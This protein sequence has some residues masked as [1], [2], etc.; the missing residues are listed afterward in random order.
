MVSVAG[1]GG[2]VG[3][4]FQD[5]RG[6][7]EDGV[8]LHGRSEMA[9]VLREASTMSESGV[10]NSASSLVLFPGGRPPGAPDMRCMI[11][12]RGGHPHP[13]HVSPR[14]GHESRP[15]ILCITF[16]WQDTLPVSSVFI[17]CVTLMT[18]L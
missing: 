7:R 17:T 11:G 12:A 8:I 10:V 14:G 16:P 4:S 2:G 5:D 13:P 18:F 3:I 6:R 1:E 9:G 15:C